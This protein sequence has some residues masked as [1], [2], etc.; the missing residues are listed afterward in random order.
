MKR[1]FKIWDKQNNCYT[2]SYSRSFHNVYEF[3]SADS[4]VND[5]CHDMF[6]NTDKYEIH[7]VE[8]TEKKIQAV[9]PKKEHLE[10]TKESKERS[11]RYEAFKKRHPDSNSMQFVMAETFRKLDWG[12]LMDKYYKDKENKQLKEKRENGQENN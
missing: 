12:P 8:I 9:P 7:E 10:K 11:E 3:D 2:G 1:I 6:H 4:A 5:N